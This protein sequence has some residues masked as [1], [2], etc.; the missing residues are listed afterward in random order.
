[1]VVFDQ[2]ICSQSLVHLK[3][4]GDKSRILQGQ[5]PSNSPCVATKCRSME[6]WECI[7]YLN[8]FLQFFSNFFLAIGNALYQ[9]MIFF[10]NQ[11]I[12]FTIDI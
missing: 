4:K 6:L 11:Y 1:M 12:D 9:V 2:N 7:T 5:V 3:I 10:F 8:F